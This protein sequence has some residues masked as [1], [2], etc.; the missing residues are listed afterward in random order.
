MVRE[1]NTKTPEFSIIIPAY[2]AEAFIQAAIQSINNQTNNDWELIIVENGSTDQTTEICNCYAD[3]KKIYLIHSEKGVS[4]ARNAGIEASKGKW[5][6]F[7]DADDQL[8]RDSLQ[9]FDEIDKKYAPDL[10]VGEYENRRSVYSGEIKVYEGNGLADFMRISLQTPTQKC[11][12]K[13]VAFRSSV[14]KGGG[15]IFD[16]QI[17]YA[18]DSVFFLEAFIH[19]KKLITLHYPVYRV[20]YHPE[21]AVRSGKKK[22]ER[23]YLMA[24]QRIDK[25][26]KEYSRNFDNDYYAFV[27]NQLLVILVNDIFARSESVASQLADAKQAMFIP[28]FKEAIEKINLSELNGVKKAVFWMMKHKMTFGLLFVARIRQS[29]NKKKVNYFYV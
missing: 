14:I 25:M 29:Q 22:L 2:N 20:I 6:I 24:I 15:I 7:L 8:L 3:N 11:N 28:E 10:I 17:C 9:Q 21:S 27:L 18:E 4:N 5:L 23:E 16:S 12:T 26:V 19:S 1:A 13:A